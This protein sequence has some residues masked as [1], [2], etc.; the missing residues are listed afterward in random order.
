M[1][2]FQASS[3]VYLIYHDIWLHYLRIDDRRVCENW[4][5]TWRKIVVE[6]SEQRLPRKPEVFDSKLPL[7]AF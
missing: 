1:E 6:N 5:N 3:A 4:D 7:R 2:N